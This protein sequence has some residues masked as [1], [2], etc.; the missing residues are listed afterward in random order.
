MAMSDTTNS[1]FKSVQNGIFSSPV[2]VKVLPHPANKLEIMIK[3]SDIVLA[4]KKIHA[5]QTKK[6]VIKSLIERCNLGSRSKLIV[7]VR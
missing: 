2:T 6:K 7:R 3:A 4:L 1:N 5:K